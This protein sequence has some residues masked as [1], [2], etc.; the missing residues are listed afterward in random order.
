MK[1]LITTLHW[2]RFNTENESEKEKYLKMSETLKEKG[3]KVFGH[4]DMNL[5]KSR[6]F[7]KILENL[8]SKT[9]E[10]ETEHLF[11][12][13]WNTEPVEG[14]TSGLRVFDWSETIFPNKKIKE[15]Y[16][17][18]QTPEMT[19]IRNNTY[20]CGYC[21]KQEYF[22][23]KPTGNLFCT[24][25]RGSEYLE[26]KDLPLLLLRPISKENINYKNIVVPGDLIADW[27]EQKKATLTAKLEQQHADKLERIRKN[28]NNSQ[29]E[30]EAFTWLINNN[31]NFD[32]VIYYS[33]SDTFCFGWINNLT[34][35]EK[36][37]LSTLLQNFPYNWEFK[38][39]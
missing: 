29:K 31:V 2:Y 26:E 6:E 7:R 8:N 18:D 4:I 22:A 34:I 1:N 12:N 9:I 39:Q 5:G 13:Q 14:S 38:K 28:I 25:C 36:E 20:K 19:E 32:N 27:K 15:G 33:H 11:N 35:E 16:W 37:K 17:L 21:G 24:K 30:L 3:L 23:Q 10:L